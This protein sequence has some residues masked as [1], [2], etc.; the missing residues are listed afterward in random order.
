MK[1]YYDSWGKIVNIEDTSDIGIGEINPIRY[2]S[3]YYD[4]ENGLY[5]LNSRYYN[6]EWGRFI[7]ADESLG[8]NGTYTGYNLYAYENNDPINNVDFNGMFAKKFLTKVG[9]LVTIAKVKIAHSF[10]KIAKG[11]IKIVKD[12]SNTLY[13]MSNAVNDAFYFDFQTGLGADVSK[14]NKNNESEVIGSGFSQTSGFTFSH[15]SF[16]YNRNTSANLHI[17]DPKTMNF[18]IIKNYNNIDNGDKNPYEIIF[19]QEDIT[20]SVA[21]ELQTQFIPNFASFVVSKNIDSDDLFIGINL[22]TS[23]VTAI[24][25]RTGFNIDLG[26]AYKFNDFVENQIRKIIF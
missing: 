11:T 6:P 26:F 16:E 21:V 17:G 14:N 19:D 8:K 10:L 12:V 2:R 13:G 23:Q 24:Q 4:N 1:Y 15:S 9:A 3:Y 22:G 25:C 7:S 18:S 20:A 5:Y